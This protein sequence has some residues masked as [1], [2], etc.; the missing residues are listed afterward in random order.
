MKER[1]RELEADAY[2]IHMH[3]WTQAEFLR[4][5]LHCREQSNDAFDIEAAARQAIEFIV[6]L[7]KA[8]TPSVAPASTTRSGG[9][10]LWRRVAR[11]TRSRI[12]S[13]LP[14]STKH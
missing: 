9:T 11:R 1:A 6:V 13:S 10:A 14:R 12:L 8:G 5:V 4:L 2:S 3:V 7:R